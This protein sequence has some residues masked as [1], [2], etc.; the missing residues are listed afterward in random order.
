M[1]DGVLAT[2]GGI[3]G[4]PMGGGGKMAV[5]PSCSALRTKECSDDALIYDKREGSLN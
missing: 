2:H 1:S 4:K 3:G 5:C